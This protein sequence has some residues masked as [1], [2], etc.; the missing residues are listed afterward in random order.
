M[1]VKIVAWVAVVLALAACV[2][3]AYAIN[4]GKPSET[5]A[6]VGDRVYQRIVAEV[7]AEVLPVYEDFGIE[8]PPDAASVRELLRPLLSV[9]PVLERP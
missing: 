6:D 9:D 4:I 1:N 8:M 2:M 5:A 7:R 3:A